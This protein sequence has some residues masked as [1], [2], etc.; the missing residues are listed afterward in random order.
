[1][2]R[3]IAYIGKPIFADELLLKPKNSLMKQSYHALEAEMTVNGDGLALA[4]ITIIAE[5]S[6]HCSDL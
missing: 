3:F 4:G 2:C 1:M 6:L 5:K